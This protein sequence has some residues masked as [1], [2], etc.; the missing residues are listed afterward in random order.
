MESF[1]AVPI[2]LTETANIVIRDLEPSE[3]ARLYPLLEKM[4]WMIPLPAAAACTIAEVN[5]EIVG[6]AVAQLI[7][8]TE[9]AWVHPA[10]RGTGVAGR[11][12]SAIRENMEKCGFT[13]YVCLA[14]NQASVELCKANGMKEITARVF[15]KG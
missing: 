12:A 6:F 9:P 13:H 15:V 4:G 11:L 3:S 2:P 8:H 10:W 7:P 1:E 14:T 5:G